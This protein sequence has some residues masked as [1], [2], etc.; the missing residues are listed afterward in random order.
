MNLAVALANTP[1]APSRLAAWLPDVGGP[2]DVDAGEL[3]DLRRAVRGALDALAEGRGPAQ[4]FVD[5]LNRASE[6]GPT[7][8]RL[9]AD[10]LCYVTLASPDDAFLADVAADAIKLIG[11]PQRP[12][13]RRCLA[14][15]CANI[16]LASRSRQTWCSERCGVRAR[17]ARHRAA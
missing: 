7:Y 3:L 16:Y 9:E 5:A 14:P 1:A 13:V 17:V 11:G 4:E 2:E 12:L 10:E 8:A 6:A 15:G